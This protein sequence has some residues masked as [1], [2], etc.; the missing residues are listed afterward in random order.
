MDARRFDTLAR[1]LAT[2]ATRRHLLRLLP[3]LGLGGLLAGRHRRAAAQVCSCS[4][5]CAPNHP[6]F[7]PELCNASCKGKSTKIIGGVIGGGGVRLAAGGEAYLALVATR[8]AAE[9]AEA[10]EFLGQ[11]RWVDLDE[12]LTLTS[13][14]IL[15]YGPLP[16]D[17]RGREAI[18]LARLAD[19]DGDVPFVLRV[20]VADPRTAEP[21]TVHLVAGDAALASLDDL[22]DPPLEPG[23]FDYEAEG[24]LID[25]GLALLRLEVAP[26]AS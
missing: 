17:E 25:G 2:G 4:Y 5:V 24:E 23:D 12:D 6:C 16:D 11:L 8:L 21:S 7:N 1:S 9:D 3:A 18:G 22:V 19:D 13:H 15:N 20:V 10:A 26:P 14:E